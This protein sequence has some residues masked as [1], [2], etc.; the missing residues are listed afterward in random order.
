MI[1]YNCRVQRTWC[2]TITRKGAYFC[3]AGAAQ[4]L[5]LNDGANAWPIEPGWWKTPTGANRF[6]RQKEAL[7]PHCG[8][9]IPMERE[10]LC[11]RSEKNSPRLLR[12]FR[13]KKLKRAHG[14]DME[15]FDG[16]F[17]REMLRK[18]SKTWYPGNYRGDLAADTSAEE[19]HG[20]PDGI[21]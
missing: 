12:L 2:P 21:L 18:N 1:L 7:C 8:M 17:T 19:G 13:A 9:A 20:L 16:T 10:L 15:V 6:L 14:R 4:N 5:L 3:E 11:K